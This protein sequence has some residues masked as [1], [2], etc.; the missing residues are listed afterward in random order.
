MGLERPPKIILCLIVRNSRISVK[1]YIYKTYLF[2]F[3]VPS[4]KIKI[5]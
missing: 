5:L 4:D 1:F 3:D 2:P